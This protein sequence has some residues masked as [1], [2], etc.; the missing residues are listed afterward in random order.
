MTTK[1]NLSTETDVET[2]G[3]GL[4]AYK[5]G[6]WHVDRWKTFR[7]RFGIYEQRQSGQHMVRA[8]VPGGRLS[9]DQ[10]LA[11]ARANASFAGGDVHITTRQGVQ[12]YF[13]AL[14]SLE[15]LLRSLHDGGVTTREASGNTFRAVTACP[16]AGHCGAQL[17]DAADAARQLTANWLRH[18]LTQHM[19][20]KFKTTVSG[21]AK[22]CGLG[23][24]DDLAFI[25]TENAT[26]EKGFRVLAGGGLGTTPSQ[27]IELFDFVSEA[28]LAR[29]QEAV[30]RVHHAQST[31]TNKNKARLKFLVKRL[32]VD[33]FVS[34]VRQAFDALDGY[35]Q[36]AWDALDWSRYTESSLTSVTVDV[37]LGWLSSAQLE[38]LAVLAKDA[39]ATELRLTRRQNITVVG[40]T[41]DQVA[42]FKRA[43]AN[44][45]LDASGRE[46]T[47]SRL[48]ACPGTSTCAI[49]I[50]DSFAL[51][52]ALL[53]GALEF[54]HIEGLT[55]SVSGCHNSCAHHHIADIGFHGLAKKIDGQPAPHYQL[56]LGGS[57]ER[58]AIAGPTIPARRV[59]RALVLLLDAIK[60]DRRE[61]ETVRDWAERVGADTIDEILRPVLGD[62]DGDQA[63]VHFDIGQD[64]RFTPPATATGEC[65]AGAVVAEHLADLAEVARL[66]AAR[67]QKAGDEIAV[68]AALSDALDYPLQRLLVISGTRDPG[69][70]QARLVAV[71]NQWA[72]D[73][74]LIAELDRAQAVLEDR[75]V[76]LQEAIETLARWQAVVDDE[77]ERIL[78][79]AN[80]FAPGHGAQAWAGAAQ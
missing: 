47:L 36:P 13:I 44:L 19:P 52:E 68:R 34:A 14:H 38:G 40:V 28:D 46:H 7:L 62:G 16:Q 17:T 3:R 9:P 63:E 79:A 27:A 23:A 30:A 66:D 72:H 25:A 71:R 42:A 53:D 43:V 64:H 32:G 11:I 67:A 60:A 76:S 33:G 78:S 77:V 21:C 18:P 4:E 65:A 2:F 70:L 22:D 50:N 29:V 10:A 58:F 73:G 20:R 41:F 35:D 26:G 39:G 56:H 45:G 61:G 75:P 24:I 55:V 48:V 54:A 6:R 37:P 74:A 31:R 8:K 12:L 5:S 1:L 69:R 15:G 49:G 80:A 59:K 57:V 51:G